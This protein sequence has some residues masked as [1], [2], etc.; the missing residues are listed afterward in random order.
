MKRKIDGAIVTT[1]T[2]NN[3]GNVLQR[4][5]MQEFLRQNGYNFIQYYFFGYYWKVYFIK[6]SCLFH[7]I[8]NLYRI[9]KR[10]KTVKQSANMYNYAEL[11]KFCNER[12]KQK[13]FCKLFLAKYSK[14]IIGSDQNL[15]DRVINREFFTNWQN[16]LLGFVKW[17]AK[18]IS[19]ASSFGRDD[20]EKDN[21][22][23][24]ERA[25]DLMLKFDGSFYDVLC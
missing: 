8:R 20:L 1:T 18:R 3:Y 23:R 16:F 5:A 9:I 24:S 21:I 2:N 12:I 22:M 7:P 14:Y 19:Y 10:R 13:W 25:K 6:I 15:N 17:P 4:Y 11:S